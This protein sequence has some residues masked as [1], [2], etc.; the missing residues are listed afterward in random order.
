MTTLTVVN[1]TPE[2]VGLSYQ[3]LAVGS[4]FAFRADP[5]KLLVKSSPE[6]FIQL[7][8]IVATALD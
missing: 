8:L 4:A 1:A 2:P 6:H 7:H 3:D 5:N